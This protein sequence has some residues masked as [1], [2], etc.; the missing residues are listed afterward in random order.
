MLKSRMKSR[1]VFLKTRFSGVAF[2]VFCLA[3]HN[4]ALALFNWGN[5]MN[6]LQTVGFI[7]IVI[8]LQLTLFRFLEIKITKKKLFYALIAIIV[9]VAGMAWYFISNCF[10]PTQ[11][12][13]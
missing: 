10:L 9:I 3:S 12:L 11:N 7:I 8:I 4:I 5:E 13:S 6:I 2:G 1:L